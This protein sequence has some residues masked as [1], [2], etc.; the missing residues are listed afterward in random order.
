MLQVDADGTFRFDDVP[1]GA[2]LVLAS[3]S[4]STDVASSR[5]NPKERLL[6]PNISR[7]RGFQAVTV[8]LREVSVA[9]GNTVAL[10]LTDRNHWFRGVIEERLLDAVG[11]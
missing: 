10:E 1:A 11:R 6:F 9:G 3:Y 2:W 4:V 5:I 8:W 7:L